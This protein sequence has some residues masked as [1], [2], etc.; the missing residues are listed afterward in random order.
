MSHRQFAADTAAMCDQLGVNRAVFIGESTGSM[1]QLSLALDRPD[2]VAASVLSAS[3][4]LWSRARR[5]S[6][7]TPD[8]KELARTWF[9]DSERDQRCLPWLTTDRDYAGVARG[10]AESPVGVRLCDNASCGACEVRA[11]IFRPRSGGSGLYALPRGHDQGCARGR[12]PRGVP[13]PLARP[14]G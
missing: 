2:L 6:L 13:V 12:W 9:S 5:A 7:S 4:F 10:A 14:E 1:L 11:A 8:P 3:T